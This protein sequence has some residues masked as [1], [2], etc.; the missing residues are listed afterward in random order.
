[1]IVSRRTMLGLVPGMPFALRAMAQEATAPRLRRFVS[2]LGGFYV[3]EPD[4]TVKAWTDGQVKASSLGLGDDRLLPPYVAQ[5]V[6]ALKGATVIA[7]G[8]VGYAVMPDGRV[9]AWGDNWNGLLGNTPVAELEATAQQHPPVPT[10]TFTL[11]MPKIVDIAAGSRHALALTADGA[12]FAWGNGQAGQLG[13]GDLPIVNF[14]TRPPDIHYFVPYPI[15]VPGLADVV[16]ISAGM[17]FSLALLKDG[18][19][20]GWGENNYGQL[21]DGTT[22]TR[23]RPVAA[24]GITNAIAIGAGGLD[25]SVA[26]LKDG[27]VATWGRGG[28][29]LGRPE[30]AHESK[31]PIPTPV[32]PVTGVTAIAVGGAHVLTLRPDGRIVSWGVV[33]VFDPVGHGP[34]PGPTPAAVP[35]VTTARAISAG[36]LSSQALLADGT[37]MAWGALPSLMFRVDD[38]GDGARYP[39]PLVVK[40]L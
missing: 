4:G 17:D 6:P 28:A 12:V 27:T 34:V 9:L 1:M 16:A 33:N 39:V 11:P 25:Y 10:P 40:G 3:T 29:S 22:E 2:G 35:I 15:Q 20:R 21:G 32:P 24:R 19:I 5:E 38:G 7:G 18:T 36:S 31:N 30:I 14:K 23:R 37:F 26:L 13:I 8:S